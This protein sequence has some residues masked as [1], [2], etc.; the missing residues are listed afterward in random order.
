LTMST[1][2]IN[3]MR[4][5]EDVLRNCPEALSELTLGER[6]W[7]QSICICVNLNNVTTSEKIYL[8]DGSTYDLFS[9]VVL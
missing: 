6:N 5:L 7:L 8:F 4:P 1:V 9:E 3:K 2:V